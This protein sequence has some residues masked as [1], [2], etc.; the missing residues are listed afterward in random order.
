[1]SA[2]IRWSHRLTMLM[3]CASPGSALAYHLGR[4]TFGPVVLRSGKAP[5]GDGTHPVPVAGTTTGATEAQPP[6]SI[7]P[8]EGAR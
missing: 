8:R 4:G 2:N 1:M 6:L 7:W 3:A 5:E